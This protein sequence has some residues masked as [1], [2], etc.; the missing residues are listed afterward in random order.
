MTIGEIDD[1]EESHNIDYLLASDKSK[2]TNSF[3][4]FPAATNAQGRN[5]ETGMELHFKLLIFIIVYPLYMSVHD[6]CLQSVTLKFNC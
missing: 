6:F 1:Y 2:L 4:S 3:A 5:Q